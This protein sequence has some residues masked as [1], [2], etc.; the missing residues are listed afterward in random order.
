MSM[1]I[2]QDK[3]LLQKLNS[4]NKRKVQWKYH[5]DLFEGEQLSNCV[6]EPILP[7]RLLLDKW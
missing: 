5:T 4:F 1:Y 6:Y 3:N 2:C 7:M